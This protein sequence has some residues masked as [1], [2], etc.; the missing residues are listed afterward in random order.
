MSKAQSVAQPK[1]QPVQPKPR[2]RKEPIELPQRAAIVDVEAV[3]RMTRA[4]R[5]DEILAAIAKLGPGRAVAFDVKPEDAN[6]FRAG[7]C[8][9]ARRR[10]LPTV[11]RFGEGKVYFWNDPNGI[12]KRVRKAKTV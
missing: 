3:P 5:Y 11:G 4:S 2:T 12:H 7:I 1:P 8:M 10:G 9:L 6:R